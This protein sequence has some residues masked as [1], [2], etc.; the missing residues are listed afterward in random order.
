[1]KPVNRQSIEIE[2]EDVLFKDQKILVWGKEYL[3]KLIYDIGEL[4]IEYRQT[5]NNTIK[6]FIILQEV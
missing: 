6:P 3:V 4:V 1:M 5:T 2:R